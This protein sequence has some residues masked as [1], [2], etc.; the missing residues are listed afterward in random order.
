MLLYYIRHAD[1]IYEPDSLT[2]LG[3]RQAE[4]LSRRLARF[5]LDEL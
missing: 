2:P 1:P 3:E 5:G 4:A